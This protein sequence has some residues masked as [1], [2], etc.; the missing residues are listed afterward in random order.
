[1]RAGANTPSSQD[2]Y[3]PRADLRKM[4]DQQPL[5]VITPG[6]VDVDSMAGDEPTKQATAVLSAFNAALAADN[7]AALGDC[8][9]ASQAYWKDQLALTYHMRTFYTPSAIAASF[10]ETKS[11]RGISGELKLQGPAGFLPATPT[12]VSD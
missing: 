7:V 9:L 2:E 8:F 6:T 11:L 3:P 4:L 5:P 10:L 12:L 1:M